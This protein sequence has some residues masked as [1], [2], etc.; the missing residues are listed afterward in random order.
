MDFQAPAIRDRSRGVPTSANVQKRTLVVVARAGS[1][2]AFQPHQRA[3]VR[4][5]ELSRGRLSTHG[6][7]HE[8]VGANTFDDA[9]IGNVHHAMRVRAETADSQK[10]RIAGDAKRRARAIHVDRRRAADAPDSA[11]VVGDVDAGERIAREI[12]DQ[13]LA[14]IGDVDR[15][16]AASPDADKGA[17]SIPGIAVDLELRSGTIDIER[18][19]DVVVVRRAGDAH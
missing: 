13:E 8:T 10:A 16:F 9:A 2:G 6:D 19:L 5:M 14:A 15:A 3:G 11:T 7:E 18:A 4:D 1:A 12:L 17:E